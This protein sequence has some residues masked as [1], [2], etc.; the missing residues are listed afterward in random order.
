MK[1]LAIE[2]SCDETAAA[3]LEKK[4]NSIS[5][6]SSVISSSVQ[7]H[8]LTGGIIPEQAARE[9]IKL[10]LPVISTTLSEAG[11][12]TSSNPQERLQQTHLA[13]SNNIDAFAVTYGP[14]LIG[15]LLIGVETAKT[16]AFV[17]G[18]PLVPTNHLLAHIYANFIRQDI[19]EIPFPFIGLIVSGGHT[20]L[21]KF[22][23]FSEY[24][25]LGGTRDDAAGEAFDKIG[26]LMNLPYPAGPVIE[27]KAREVN[28]SQFKFS[29]P[30]L[31]SDDFD[32]SFSGLKTEVSRFIKNHPQLTEQEVNEVCYAVQDSITDVLVSKTLKAAEQFGAQSIVVGGGV[33][34][35]KALRQRFENE[36]NKQNLNIPFFFPEPKY[37]TDNAAMIGAAALLDYKPVLWQDIKSNPELYFV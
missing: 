20:D 25:W 31:H 29:K 28:S 37:T 8:A 21:L 14:G 34:N 35:N 6:L 4:D 10:I 23:S 5:V 19:S 30:L 32:F 33:S 15:S 2:S 16:L 1:I 18:K 13:I 7:L 36:I 9:Q 24:K 17:F 3:I 11:M 27:Q 22:E 12:T 26:R